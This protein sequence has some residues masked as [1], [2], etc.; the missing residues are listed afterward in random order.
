MI[1]RIGK[2]TAWIW[3]ELTRRRVIKT[4]IAYVVMA[5]IIVEAASTIFPSLLLPEWT[6]RLVTV[7]AILGLPL[8]IILAWTFDIQVKT[9]SAV[10]DS[11]TAEVR[12]EDEGQTQAARIPPSPYSAVASVAVMPF[13]NLSPHG[14]RRFVADGIATELQS[15][16]AKVHRLRVASRTSS[17]SLASK[18]MTV[19]E[20]GDRLNVHFVISGSVE[21]IEDH[22]RIIVELDNADEGVQ[23]WTATYDRELEDIFSIQKEIA[24]AITN[25]FPGA[26]LRD[27]IAHAANRPTEILDAWSLVQRAR[28]FTLSFTPKALAD[29]VPLLHQAIDLDSE[30]AAAHAALASVLSEQVLN[31][32]SEKPEADR[33]TALESAERAISNTPMDPFV[34]KM[35]GVVW[36]YFG[37]QESSFEALRR[38]V[39]I[40][41]FDFGAWGFMGWPLTGS[42]S[43]NDLEE[44]HGIMDRILTATPMH[45]GAPY[46]MY[47]RSVAYTCQG[48][49]Q[50]AVDFARKSVTRNPGFPWALMQYAN[51]L[52]VVGDKTGA[53]EATTRCRKISPGLTTDHYASMIHQM[54]A[55]S[56]ISAR[57]M[58]GI[59]CLN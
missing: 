43:R 40:A 47:H 15:I 31:G 42:G 38:A 45:P 48:Q 50:K 52:G 28:S 56:S 20:I 11:D 23:I 12:K 57:R 53:I 32:L 1:S 54:T 51:A 37:K 30:Y 49:S 5:L 18:D 9:E 22:M 24:T 26:R 35:C 34:L 6:V 33:Q 16:L 13:R 44:V 25:G 10:P 46:W 58:A 14:H 7:I 29:A 55:N 36:A 3:S 17:F 8:V 4:S 39:D 2:F 19:R 59:E 21:C 41:P 27:E